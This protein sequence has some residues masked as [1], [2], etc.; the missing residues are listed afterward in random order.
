MNR[1]IGLFCALTVG[2]FTFIASPKPANAE[3][4]S[5]HLEPGVVAPLNFP[6]NSIYQPGM[7]L[8][9][10]GMFALQPWLTVGP[11]AS[12]SYF[13][14]L[15]D[16]G[17]NA[18]VLWQFG[19][20]LRLQRNRSLFGE[21][22]LGNWSPWVDV[23]IMAAHTGNLWR[24]SVDVGVGIETAL[25]HNHSAWMGPFVRYTHVFQTS[26]NQDG[27]ML[28]DHDVNL[29]QV[30]L[31]VS[32]DFPTRTDTK[33]VTKVVHDAVAAVPCPAANPEVVMEFREKV[34]FDWDKS[35]LRWE[36]KDKID[37]VIAKLNAQPHVS[38]HVQGHASL[39]GNKVHNEKLAAARADAVRKYLVDH[40]V[41][42]SRLTVDSFGVDRPSASN[43]T[44][45]GRE[46]NRRVEFEV[47][48]L[49]ATS[50]SK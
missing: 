17:L 5:L 45:E 13:P 9:A 10:K 23:D 1:T 2:A 42:A 16:N 21:N 6:Q 28:D 46:R 32:F 41:D 48:F 38:V 26:D 3:N 18:G 39:D 36:S 8:G 22:D 47:S 30:G 50:S 15:T 29:L 34:Y 44:Q 27:Q 4:F 49:T 35:V 25:D 20:S 11:S 33:V 40:G 43:G 19:G 37:N 12:A 31:S 7:V 14:R 24:P